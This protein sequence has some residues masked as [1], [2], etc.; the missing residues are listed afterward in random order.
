MT[1]AREP[2]RGLVHLA[3]L[4]LV[5]LSPFLPVAAQAYVGPGSGLG[6]IG[7]LLAVLG[8]IFFAIVGIVWYPIKRLIRALKS[9]RAGDADKR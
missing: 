5:A 6:A 2:I 8:T 9:K 1:V 4:A 3:S 7:A